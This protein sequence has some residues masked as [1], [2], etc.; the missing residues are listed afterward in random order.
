MKIPKLLEFLKGML[1]QGIGIAIDFCDSFAQNLGVL[2][3]IGDVL[4]QTM[5][6]FQLG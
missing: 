2:K 3:L 5:L 1:P 4:R 6:Q